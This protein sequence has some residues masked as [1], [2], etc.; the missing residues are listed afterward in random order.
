MA[1]TLLAYY[2]ATGTTR[3]ITQAIHEVLDCDVY[4]ILPE[5]EYT[6][7]DLNW[8]DES[9]RATVEQKD[10]TSR[11]ALGSEDIDLSS[12]DRV[13]IGFPVWWYT[14]PRLIYTFLDGQKLAD[15]TLIPFATSGGSGIG[16]SQED[17]EKT[18]KAHWEP[19]ARFAPGQVQEAKDWA[20]S[21]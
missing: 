12:Y 13:L 9:T 6:E 5:E 1:K 4:E 2:S 17:L 16:G 15:T 21:L 10:P 18:Y 19:G 14:A 7:E 20:E 3:E 11:P 8:R